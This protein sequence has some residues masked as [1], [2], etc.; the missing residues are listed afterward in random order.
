M[1]PPGKYG[2]GRRGRGR[3]GRGCPSGEY[4]RVGRRGGVGVGTR[5]CAGGAS[6]RGRRTP[7]S[8]RWI[9]RAPS[10]PR[11]GGGPGDRERS[12]RRGWPPGTWWDAREGRVPRPDRARDEWEPSTSRFKTAR[13]GSSSVP[14]SAQPLPGGPRGDLRA[15]PEAKLGEDVGDVGLDGALAD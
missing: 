15:R 13:D 4:G 12:D 6:R 3:W 8:P 11:G 5:T 1:C 2:R 14:Y 9:P 7:S 10:G